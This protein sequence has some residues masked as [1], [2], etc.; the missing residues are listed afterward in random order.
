MP[1]SA[2]SPQNLEEAGGSLPEQPPPP[3]VLSALPAW[4]RP[5]VMS[6]QNRLVHQGPQIVTFGGGGN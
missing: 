2:W 5:Q 4:P 1:Q 3:R 6:P